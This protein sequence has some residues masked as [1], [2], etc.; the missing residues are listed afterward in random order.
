MAFKPTFILSDQQIL[1]SLHDAAYKEVEKQLNTDK[2]Q[3][4]NSGCA[5]DKN[6]LKGMLDKTLGNEI[7]KNKDGIYQIGIAAEL[8]TVGTKPGDTKFLKT[9]D[10]SKLQQFEKDNKK[11]IESFIKSKIKPIIK[12]YCTKFGGSKFA[13]DVESKQLS[14]FMFS[15][16]ECA[17]TVE[18]YMIGKEKKD[19]LPATCALFVFAYEV[20]GNK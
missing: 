7:F 9:T 17:T 14:V 1:A 19:S 6:K 13:K 4:I 5:V 2:V 15:S 3:L 11:E 18:K 10:K 12:T 8:Q 20:G 16:M